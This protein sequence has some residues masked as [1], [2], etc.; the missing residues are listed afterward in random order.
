[1]SAFNGSI[2]FQN[3]DDV[4]IEVGRESKSDPVGPQGQRLMSVS[5]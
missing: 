1:M 4:Y 2:M 5:P 3:I